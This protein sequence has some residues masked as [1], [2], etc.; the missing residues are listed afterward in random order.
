MRKLIVLG[1]LILLL[2]TAFSAGCIFREEKTE[3]KEENNEPPVNNTTSINITELYN[4]PQNPAENDDITI[5]AKV[6]SEKEVASVMIVT[7]VGDT[8]N[9][10]GE[11]TLKD[12]TL[13]TYE[14]TI[15]AGI[16][17]QGNE[18]E[19]KV[20]ATDTEDNSDY[21]EGTFTVL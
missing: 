3:K 1:I 5:Y 12:G 8:C 16:Y 7:C 11:M 19:Y 21:V 10:A 15:D 14:Y 13:D 6:I 20:T 17:E 18:V 2:L 9:L 4:E